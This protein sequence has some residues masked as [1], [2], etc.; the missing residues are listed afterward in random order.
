[1]YIYIQKKKFHIIFTITNN[2]T[3]EGI[4]QFHLHTTKLVNPEVTLVT[5]SLEEN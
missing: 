2:S 5:A 1:M 3:L 4:G